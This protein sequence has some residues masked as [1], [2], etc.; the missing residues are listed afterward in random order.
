MENKEQEKLQKQDI[1]RHS[2]SHVFGKALCSL[3]KGTKLTIGPAIEDGFYYD[4]DLNESITPQHMAQITAK[5][6]EI[7]E[8]NEDFKKEV[9]TRK[10]ALELFKDNPYKTELIKDLPENEEVS[11]YYLG[12]DWFDLC[13]GPHVENTKFL[14][15]FAYKFNKVSGAY[16]RG[17]SKNKMLQRAYFYG[18]DDK[19]KLKEHLNMLAEAEKRDN[20]KLGKELGLFT[21]MPE[22]AVGMPFFLEKGLIVKNQ[23]AD[24]WKDLHKR[25]GYKEIETPIILNRKLWEVSGHW[26]NYKAGMYSL[27]IDDED[28]AIKPMS[29]P[30]A[31]LLYK[32]KI[33]SYKEFPLKLAELGRVH[34][35]EMSGAIGGLMRVRSFVQDDAHIFLTERQV[36]AEVI[37]IIENLVNPI[38]KMFGLDF[39]KIEISTMPERHIGTKADWDIAEQALKLA[40]DKLK[41]K[42]IINEGDGAFYGP[43]ID[44][45]IKDSIGRAW[46]CGTIQYDMNL[47]GRFG[48]KYADKD[49]VFQVPIMLHRAVYGSLERFMGILIEHF[50]GEFPFWLSPVQVGIVPVSEQNNEYAQKI[51]E[52]LAAGKLRCEADLSDNGM[53]KKVNEYRVNKVPYVLILGDKEQADKTVSVKIRGG[54]QINDIKLKDF[55]KILKDLND[56]K[57]LKLAEEF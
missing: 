38:Y 4:F 57:C 7:I 9:V 29:C 49:G 36:E 11:I 6:K 47:P 10:R 27:S 24:Y 19:Q 14:R 54:K 26:D 46:Q 3:Y 30:G 16:W 12:D 8:A 40:L 45:H 17:D 21:F 56:S 51:Y 5:M 44:F 28:Y 22:Y 53:G 41:I 20:R 2:M 18:F 34:R 39:A 55:I 35:H 33:H 43:K 1:M 50:A 32:E 52:Q 42:Y 25:Q 37:S 31:L 48:L 23:L 15:N 13:R